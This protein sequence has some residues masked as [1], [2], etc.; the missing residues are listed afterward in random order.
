MEQLKCSFGAT[1]RVL[2]ICAFFPQD[3]VM[4]YNDLLLIPAGATN[5]RIT[6][7]RCSKTLI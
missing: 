7:V 1:G 3:L 6:E 4:G 2:E 5:I